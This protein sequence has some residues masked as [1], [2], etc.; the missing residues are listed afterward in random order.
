[1]V[2]EE[3]ASLYSYFDFP[4]YFNYVRVFAEQ[5]DT[6]IRN[7]FA[8]L[9]TAHKYH[10]SYPSWAHPNM[11]IGNHDNVRIGNLISRRWITSPKT[12]KYWRV[13]FAIQLYQMLYPGPITMYYGEEIGEYTPCYDPEYGKDCNGAANDNVARSNITPED[14]LTAFQKAH[15]DNITA[16]IKWRKEHPIARCK[17]CDYKFV[18]YGKM[19]GYFVRTNNGTVDDK[20]EQL[21][22][23]SNL[24]A[25]KFK[26]NLTFNG[27]LV[28]VLSG[29]KFNGT[30]ELEFPKMTTRLFAI[31]PPEKN[32]SP[33]VFILLILCLLFFIF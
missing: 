17:T 26:F 28:D 33:K 25:A 9:N 21:I 5:T 7:T 1:M 27:T 11:F 15:R 31:Y 13:H 2:K 16:L 18:S 4:A 23:M 8:E 32:A 29:E 20:I 12:Y 3:K 10:R 6:Q 30:G 24:N 14:K 22:Y 19:R